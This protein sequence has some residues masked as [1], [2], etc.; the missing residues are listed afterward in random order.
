M[1]RDH[2]DGMRPGPTPERVLAVCRLLILG[3]LS[4]DELKDQIYL[5]KTAATKIG[6]EFKRS[7][8]AA[9]ELGLISFKDNMYTL[10]V[11]TKCLSTS[12]NFRRTCAKLAFAN[13]KSTFFRVCRWYVCANELVF[14]GQNWEDKAVHAN[15]AGVDQ[16]D[17]NAMLGWRFWASFLGLG[18]VH[19]T[20]LIPNMYIRVRDV[21]ATEFT[22]EF[23]FDEEIPVDQFFNWLLAKTPEAKMDDGS[24]NLALSSAIRTLRDMGEIE[25]VSLMDA[26][27]MYLY[28]L[29]EDTHN[30]ITHIIVK[31]AVCK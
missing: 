26:V 13:K 23:S 29:P 30:K 19:G 18:Y 27:P 20:E 8:S 31:E 15:Q 11:D 3:S 17:E 12:E 2:Y 14:S 5:E 25:P 22:K 24:I 1:F 10:S 16:V 6:E 4:E 9:T 7:L 28:S 21:L